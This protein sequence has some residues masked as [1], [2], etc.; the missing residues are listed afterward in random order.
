MLKLIGVQLSPFVR[1]PL[2]AL[3]FK[4]IEY[5]SVHMMPFGPK[6]DWF[7]AMSPLGKLPVLDHDGFVVADSSV[8]CR[9]LEDVFPDKPIYP[10]DARDSARACFLEEYGDSKLMDACGSLFQQRFINPNY[11]DEPTDEATVA[12]IVDQD[13]PPLLAYLESVVPA[14]DYLFGA[15]LTI[16]DFGIVSPFLQAAYAGY[17]P[18][19]GTWPALTAYLDRVRHHPVVVGR[20]AAEAGVMAELMPT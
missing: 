7:Q 11:R 19:P 6:P 9:Y 14:D 17:A 10:S 8:I 5:E 18:D 2:L 1:K 4:G 12:R 16:A 13:L 20:L 15:E 3:E